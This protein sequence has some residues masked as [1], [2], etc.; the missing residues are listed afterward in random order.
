MV[1]HFKDVHNCNLNA[2]CIDTDGSFVCDCNQGFPGSG[3]NCSDIDECD[4]NLAN[5]Q[6]FSDCIN[7]V[8]SYSCICQAGFTQPSDDVCKDIDECSDF[9]CDSNAICQNSVGN[10]SC[11]CNSG[12]S[13]LILFIEKC[14]TCFEDRFIFKIRFGKFCNRKYQ[15]QTGSAFSKLEKLTKFTLLAF[16]IYFWSK[17]Q[18]CNKIWKKIWNRN[19]LFQTGNALKRHNF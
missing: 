19:Y 14:W 9:P 1:T 10:F 13:W 17:L 15:S 4:L 8:G 2:D 12:M 5:C 11:E 3:E 6:E 16:W 18:I 7:T